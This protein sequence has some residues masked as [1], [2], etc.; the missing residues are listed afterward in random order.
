MKLIILD[1]D[2]VINKDSDAY[3]KNA[4]E[5][6]PIDGS[7]DAIAQLTRGGYTVVVATNQSG[8]GR[9]LFSPQDLEEMHQ[10]MCQLVQAAGGRINGIFFC[11]HTPEE[12][13]DCRKPKT[14]MLDSIEQAFQCC[15]KGQPFIG[16]SFKDLQAGVKKGCRPIL[17]LTGKGRKTKRQIEEESP[18]WS[19][20]VLTYTSLKNAVLSIISEDKKNDSSF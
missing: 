11:P 15:V 10:K 18:T 1:R 16:D 5:W 12:R 20:E 4:D 6:M 7:I 2:G 17:V 8:L 9:G 19:K 14:G 3:I 13:C